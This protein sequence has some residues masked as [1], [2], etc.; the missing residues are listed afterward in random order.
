[1]TEHATGLLTP[2]RES[3]RDTPRR[4]LRNL[5]CGKARPAIS[6]APANC[7]KIQQSASGLAGRLRQHGTCDGARLLQVQ[8]EA[9]GTFVLTRTWPGGRDVE[10][11]FKAQ[12]Q[13]PKLCP[14]CTPDTRRGFLPAPVALFVAPRPRRSIASCARAGRRWAQRF[15]AER[16]GWTADEIE[17]AAADLQ[18]P[19][20]EGPR[21]PEGDAE[22]DAFARV[23]TAA[24]AALRAPVEVAS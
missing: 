19:Y 12:R 10:H 22:Q 20:Y 1:M 8:R 14:H 15:L 16:G 3:A 6:G 17:Q 7:R 23:I 5:S 4:L 18:T 9:G 24:L 13:S 11:H 21:T 2:F